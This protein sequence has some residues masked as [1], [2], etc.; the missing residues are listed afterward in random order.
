MSTVHY[1]RVK[2]IST[3]TGVVLFDEKFRA[4]DAQSARTTVLSLDPTWLSAQGNF[5]IQVEEVFNHCGQKTCSC[6]DQTKHIDEFDKRYSGSGR[7]RVCKACKL[8]YPD[9]HYPDKQIQLPKYNPQ[10]IT[11]VVLVRYDIA[12]IGKRR[13]GFSIWIDGKTVGFAKEIINVHGFATRYM[14]EHYPTLT[15]FPFER[16]MQTPTG[17]R[18]T[19]RISSRPLKDRQAVRHF[20]K[21]KRLSMEDDNV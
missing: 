9:G 7:Q 17:Y 12:K 4:V 10:L 14:F 1:F 19:F 21:D 18:A 20:G 2:L 5:D 15:N 11:D 6:C 8:A 13:V 16:F 3:I